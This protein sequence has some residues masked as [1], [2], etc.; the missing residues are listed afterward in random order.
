MTRTATAR[1]AGL[2]Y[3]ATLPTVA[4][5]YGYADHQGRG[6]TRRGAGQRRHVNP[7]SCAS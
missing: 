1:L 3:L 5:A 6:V 4:F 2:L 7:F